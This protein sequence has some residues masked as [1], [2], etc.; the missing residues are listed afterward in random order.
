M[1][2]TILNSDL[3]KERNCLK[4]MEL[5]I[6]F[7]HVQFIYIACFPFN[8]WQFLRA[9]KFYISLHSVYRAS[10]HPCKHMLKHEVPVMANRIFC[11]CA[12][13]LFAQKSSQ[14]AA[15]LLFQYLIMHGECVSSAK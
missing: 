5:V 4:G 15:D 7:S 1:I 14:S 13:V 12:S 11:I 9:F 2:K 8:G 3:V 6:I 10:F